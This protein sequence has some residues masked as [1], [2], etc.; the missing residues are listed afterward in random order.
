[1]QTALT[2][3]SETIDTLRT[4]PPGARVLS[5]YVD[6]SPGRVLG[7][8]HLLNF[9][10]ACDGLRPSLPE[11]TVRVYCRLRVTPEQPVEAR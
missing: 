8:G 10:D 1:M 9:N 11:E 5:F 2:R 6:T 4:S 3:L 7:R